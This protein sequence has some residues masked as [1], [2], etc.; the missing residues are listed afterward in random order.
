VSL[1]TRNRPDS[2]PSLGSG[3]EG[4]AP[5]DDV[6][7]RLDSRDKAPFRRAIPVYVK[8]ASFIYRDWFVPALDSQVIANAVELAAGDGTIQ[9]K[10]LCDSRRVGAIEFFLFSP[11]APLAAD[12]IDRRVGVGLRIGGHHHE[13]SKRTQQ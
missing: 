2:G 11:E 5:G 10:T 9:T 6:A 8:L 7:D 12:L 13:T 4:P 1:A 3:I